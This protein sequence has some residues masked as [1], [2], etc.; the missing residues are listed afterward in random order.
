MSETVHMVCRS[1]QENISLAKSPF[2]IFKRRYIFA[3]T[4]FSTEK[5][6]L[7]I[8]RSLDFTISL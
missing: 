4:F 2:E 7:S 3:L 6:I 8:P 1:F 5:P